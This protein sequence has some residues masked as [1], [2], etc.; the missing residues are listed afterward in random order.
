[1]ANP[2][3]ANYPPP[4]VLLTGATG[5]VGGLLLKR[6]ESMR[7]GVR[8][9]ARD[10]SKLAKTKSPATETV[11]GDVLQAASLNDA[12]LGIRTAYYMVHSM[13][14]GANFEEQDRIAAANFGEAAKEAG[15]ERIVYLG[16][17]GD[18]KDPKLS[19]HLR[20][21]HE[22]GKVLSKSQVETVEFRASAVLGPGSL[23]FELIRSLTNRL[24]IMICPRWLATPTQPI[25]AS[26]LIEY[27][28]EAIDL[29]PGD[30]RVFEI[31][32]SDVVTY[33]DLI[34]EYARQ[35]GLRRRLISVPLL[36]PYLSGLWLG[37]VTPATAEVG[38]H[39]IE[40]LRNPTVVNDATAD[41]A[42]SVR[43]MST[44]KAIALAIAK[45]S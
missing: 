27:L 43:P 6:L 45:D 31:G 34:L 25:A 7:I 41:E 33:G 39:L 1:M 17:L 10:P 16:G 35:S 26:D 38:R 12:M 11:V 22:V 14:S 30:S 15:V 21:R 36:T 20:S 5:Y 42:F 4:S 32:G 3:E 13:G 40:G 44:S 8:C 37:L 24:P 28:V 18:D 2:A 19:P 23:S 9:L 29:P